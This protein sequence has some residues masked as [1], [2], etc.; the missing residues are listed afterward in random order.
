MNQKVLLRI[1]AVLMFLHTI[2][3][4]FGTLNWKNAP[5]AAVG[6]LI[7][8]MQTTHFAFMG[9]SVTLAGFYEGYGLSM[10][11]V[12]LLISVVLWFLSTAAVGELLARLLPLFAVF[13]LFLGIIEYIYFFP[14]AASFSLLAALCTFIARIRIRTSLA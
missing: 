8:G 7:S 12:L 4:S 2:G 11:F 13:L 14:F 3:H 5:D 6:R 9:R 1:A 10:I